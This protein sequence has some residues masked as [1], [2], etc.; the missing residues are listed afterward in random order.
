MRKCVTL[1]GIPI[2]ALTMDEAIGKLKEFLRA[3][4]QHHVMTP[5]SEM[6]TEARRN[7]AFAKVLSETALNVPDSVGLLWGAQVTGQKLEQRVS[8]V[9]VVERLCTDPSLG[10][11]VFFLGGR[12]GASQKALEVLSNKNPNLKIA[13]SYE[14]SPMEEEAH[15]IIARINQS[16]AQILFVAY[17]APKQD[18][19]ISEHLKE[20]PNVKVAM[21][22]GGTFDFLSGNIRRAPFMIRKIGLEWLWRL[23]LEPW[24]IKRI[25]TAVVVFP[26]LVLRYRK[27][28]L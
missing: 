27:G 2:D 17:G 3:P 26:V 24:R 12:D 25:W 16:G 28:G 22:V 7:H 11:S 19:W 6:L 8:G 14:G 13:G 15:D 18:L 1:L 10:A 9:D 23:I 21:G 5:N 20:L 4:G